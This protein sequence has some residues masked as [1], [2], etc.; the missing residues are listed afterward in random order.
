MRG[1]R[2]P[3]ALVA[4]LAAC[5]GSDP[6]NEELG[7]TSAAMSRDQMVI[8][9]LI[10]ETALLDDSAHR[11]AKT[12]DG[13]WWIPRP[14]FQLLHRWGVPIS[15]DCVRSTRWL[16]ADGDGLPYDA[17]ATLDCTAKLEGARVN[18]TGA[19]RVVDQND[20]EAHAG[21]TIELRGLTVTVASPN[22]LAN[23]TIG[24]EGKAIIGIADAQATRFERE[25]TLTVVEQ[26]GTFTM[27]NI[28]W[29][30]ADARYTPDAAVARADPWAAG[31]VEMNGGWTVQTNGINT[32]FGVW[33]D[34]PLH[35]DRDCAL[36]HPEDPGFDEG[37]VIAV[38]K[39]TFRVGFIGCGLWRTTYRGEAPPAVP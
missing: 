12:P 30:L 15:P 32:H 37:S 6:G 28:I 1:H 13:A 24:L 36:A 23:R 25:L 21:Y 29:M 14:L 9:A 22:V 27:K 18:A 35:Y 34:R 3:L 31:I 7:E 19:V 20:G 39:T 5:A 8:E 11:A 33:T 17:T 2:L 16:D 26:H 4:L 10:I 38:G